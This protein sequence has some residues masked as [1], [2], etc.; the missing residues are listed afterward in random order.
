MRMKSDWLKTLTSLVFQSITERKLGSEKWQGGGAK[1]R[2]RPSTPKG[3]R[4]RFKCKL[5]FHSRS[6]PLAP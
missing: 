6:C 5:L 4:G 1:G 2:G 3:R